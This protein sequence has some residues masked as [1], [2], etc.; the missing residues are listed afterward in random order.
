LNL[1][2]IMP[3]IS[4]HYRAELSLPVSPIS[5]T[6]VFLAIELIIDTDAGIDDAQAILLALGQPGVKV[7]A[8]T[9]LSGNVH[10]DKVTRNVLA[11]LEAV[12]CH[13]PVYRGAER[14]LLNAPVPAEDFHGADGLGE[15]NLPPPKGQ[16]EP[17][18]AALALLRMANEHPGRYTLVAIGPLTNVAL[19]TRLDPTFPDKLAAFVFMGGAYAS[20]GNTN[21]VAEFNVHSDPEAAEIVLGAFRHATMIS[22]ELSVD[23]AVPWEAFERLRS[24]HT[25]AADF[26]NKITGFLVDKFRDEGEWR[27]LPMPDPLAVAVA[28]QPD[29]ATESADGQLHVELAGRLTRGQTIVD[30][31]GWPQVTVVQRVDLDQFWQM[32]ETSLGVR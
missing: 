23:Y 32:M 2:S 7:A 30:W 17:E 25:P 22:W 18:H 6:E 9:T 20:Q 12:G 31:K 24:Q 26:F 14:P 5:S 21:I 27:G 19:A 16:V 15:T 13:V 10:V 4:L 1:L 29:L 3:S 11:T 28:I 8:I